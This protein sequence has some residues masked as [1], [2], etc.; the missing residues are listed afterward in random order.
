MSAAEDAVADYQDTP[1]AEHVN[2]YLTKLEAEGTSPDHWGN[3]RRCLHG[4]ADDCRWTRLADLDRSAFERWLVRMTKQGIGARTR[5]L[6]RASLVAFCNWCVQ[7]QPPRLASNPVAQVKKADEKADQ[8]RKRRVMTEDELT[9]LLEVARRRPL[10]DARRRGEPLPARLPAD[11]P[12]F[13]VP[14]DLVRILDR[15]LRLAGIAKMDERGRTVDVHALRTSFATH[16][17]KGGAS[18]LPK[19]HCDT[20]TLSSAP[21]STPTQ[22]SWTSTGRW[23]CCRLFQSMG[24]SRNNCGTPARPTPRFGL[25]QSPHQKLANL[26]NH[27][28]LGTKGRLISRTDPNRRTSP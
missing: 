21:T 5:S 27:G 12:V 16:L 3:V 18:G 2:A 9:K 4:I 13:R 14:R 23:M 20:A 15:D 8:R 7:C 11:T 19:R 22:S 28:Q 1:L 10:L 25:H 24:G 17:N 26:A 6:H